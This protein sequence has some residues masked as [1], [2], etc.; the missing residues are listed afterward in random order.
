MSK[1]GI[2]SIG[3][4]AC[5]HRRGVDDDK[6]CMYFMGCHGLCVMCHGLCVMGH[7]LD[8]LFDAFNT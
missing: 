2:N 4:V 8:M 5:T 1:R 7:G 6:V 3:H